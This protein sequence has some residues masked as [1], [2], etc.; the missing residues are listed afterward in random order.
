MHSNG[1]VG[2]ARWVKVALTVGFLGL[3]GGAYGAVSDP[4]TGYEL[5]VYKATPLTFWVGV[6]VALLAG[7]VVAWFGATA[8]GRTVGCVLGG[9]A[10]SAVLALPLLRGYYFLGHADT[11]T[12][13]GWVKD[14]A[15]GGLTPDELLYPGI[16]TLAVFV[17]QGARL[18]LWRALLLVVFLFC[19]AFFVFFPLAVR[20][21][22]DR[23]RIVTLAAF[24]AFLLLPVNLLSTHVQAH[25][26]TQTLLFSALVVFLL[27]LYL[28]TEGEQARGRAVGALLALSTSAMVLYHPQQAANLLAVF[29]AVAVSQFVTG[30]LNWRRKFRPIYAQTGLFGTV[31]VAWTARHYSSIEIPLS[32][33]ATGLLGYLRGSPPTAGEEVVTQAQSLSAIG[34]GLV[35]IYL[36]LF[37]VSTVYLGLAGLLA[38]AVVW[39]RTDYDFPDRLVAL[40]AVGVVA[41]SPL[42]VAYFL[43]NVSEHYFRHLGFIMLLVSVFGALALS[44]GHQLFDRSRRGG[45]GTL[46][47]YGVPVAL[48]LML[49]LSLV[50]FLP[51]PY[52]DKPNRHVTQSERAGYETALDS[53]PEDAE[54]AALQGKLY[55]YYDGIYGTTDTP[56]N[57]R[58]VSA[59]N[60]TSLGS[61]FDGE[62]YVAVSEY[63]RQREVDAYRQLR[64]SRAEFASLRT[65]T[66]VD[67]V[68]ANREMTLYR[69]G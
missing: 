31:F 2:T 24:S 47:S 45:L 13:F 41:V 3:A 67:R 64:F 21:L 43:G 19:V 5:S 8:A 62:G 10:V 22:V 66:D 36:K 27:V 48:A 40:F 37:L 7:L 4:A 15:A 16:H 11:M 59:Q 39:N 63:E 57:R 35:E 42:P 6:G 29:L 69:V 20:R 18:P 26:F 1:T 34:A 61:F 25:S 44:E 38:L 65:Q 32:N 60:M 23:D 33:L 51:S 17:G 55:R 9:G 12:Y 30:A 49:V 46:Y 50:A 54:F 52:I 58:S 53:T 28:R 56:N 14:I 68:F